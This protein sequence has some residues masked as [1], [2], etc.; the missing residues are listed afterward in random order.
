MAKKV[1]HKTFNYDYCA[2]C[3]LVVS[4]GWTLK[5]DIT[6]TLSSTTL[7][8]RDLNIFW[9]LKL[10]STKFWWTYE[11]SRTQK[12]KQ[13]KLPFTTSPFFI[14]N[15]C[16]LHSTV[17]PVFNNIRLFFVVLTCKTFFDC[18]FFD[19][20]NTTSIGFYSFLFNFKVY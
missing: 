2:R 11:F 14:Y 15:N 4:V 19:Y 13:Q 6:L 1:C 9:M 18:W 3:Y 12:K 17:V 7:N 5:C 10:S 20:R 16:I 8:T